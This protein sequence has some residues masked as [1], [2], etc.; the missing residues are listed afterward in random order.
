MDI[1]LIIGTWVGPIIAH[2]VTVVTMALLTVWLFS[3]IIKGEGRFDR[4]MRILF[5]VAGILIAYIS[6][7]SGLSYADV[8][9]QALGATRFKFAGLLIMLQWVGPAVAGLLLGWLTIRFYRRGSE[10]AVRI[11]VLLGALALFSFLLSYAWMIGA[12]EFTDTTVIIPNS[13]FVIGVI[14]SLGMTEIKPAKKSSGTPSRSAETSNPE[15]GDG[16]DDVTR[17]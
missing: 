5:F 16:H 13:M 9:S 2:I 14:L 10:R 17:Y 15:T 11:T 1:G 4:I 6:N 12:Q 8:I 3:T 7:R